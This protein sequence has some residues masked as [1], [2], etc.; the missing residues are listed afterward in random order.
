MDIY[1]LNDQPYGK[2]PVVWWIN[3]TN[4][5]KFSNKLML[6]SL[7]FVNL[8]FYLSFLVQQS[9]IQAKTKF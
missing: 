3:M 2:S 4:I 6:I 9:L 5:L 7:W 1:V 8:C